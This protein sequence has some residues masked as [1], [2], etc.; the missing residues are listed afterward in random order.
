MLLTEKDTFKLTTLSLKVKPEPV[1]A[2]RVFH[3]RSSNR[4]YYNQYKYYMR[5]RVHEAHLLRQLTH[6]YIDRAIV[7]RNS[8]VTNRWANRASRPVLFEENTIMPDI[9]D[10]L[11]NICQLLITTPYRFKLVVEKHIMRL[12]TND[13]ALFD[14]LTSSDI[15]FK[16][17][18]F[19]TRIIDQLPGTIKLKNPTHLNRSYFNRVKL[20]EQ[21][22]ISIVQ[23]FL[24]NR[25]TI[26]L[27]PSLRTWTTWRHYAWTQPHYFVDHDDESWKIMLSLI[28]PGLIK[29]ANTIVQG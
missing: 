23:F 3:E 12:Y 24:N 11:H 2:D 1:A 20:T 18:T 8:S 17:I 28:R 25:S 10:N 26:K 4:L 29:K 15:N 19:D 9:A 22:K 16:S 21:E 6:S 14:D 13:N 7:W 27:S 5:A